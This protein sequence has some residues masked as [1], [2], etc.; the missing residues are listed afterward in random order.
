MLAF[1][2]YF[3]LKK[4]QGSVGSFRSY[5]SCT[6]FRYQLVN[7]H[8]YTNE[9]GSV[10]HVDYALSNLMLLLD[11]TYKSNHLIHSYLYVKIIVGSKSM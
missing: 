4:S 1:L 10:N 11:T 3:K 5:K 7:Y 6:K 2:A 9:I 8:F